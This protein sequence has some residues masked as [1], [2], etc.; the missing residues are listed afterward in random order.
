MYIINEDTYEELES[1]T[2]LLTRKEIR[3][4]AGYARE[5]LETQKST[6]RSASFCSIS[7]SN[8]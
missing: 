5:L 1:I 4:L 2:L 8:V 6:D 7:H 3:F